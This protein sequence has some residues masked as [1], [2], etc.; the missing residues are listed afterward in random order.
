MNAQYIHDWK[1]RLLWPVIQGFLVYV[2]LLMVFD[3]VVELLG[4][5]VNTEMY[6]CMILSFLLNEIIRLWIWLFNRYLPSQI[7]GTRFVIQTLGSLVCVVLIIGGSLSAYFIYLIG[8]R[9]G[10]FD[11]ELMAFLSIFAVFTLLFNAIHLSIVLLNSQNTQKIKQEELL[12]QNLDFQVQTFKNN[13]NPTFFYESMEQF[14]ILLYRDHK[15]A[16]KFI[17]HLSERYRY[18]LENRQ[19][20]LKPL[21]QELPTLESLAFLFNHQYDHS[22]KIDNQ[23]GP[24]DTEHLVVTNTLATVVE[25]LTRKTII[26]KERPLRIRCYIDDTDDYLVFE[27]NLNERF[28]KSEEMEDRADMLVRAYEYFTSKPFVNVKAGEQTFIKIPLLR[29]QA[30]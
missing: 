12:R 6:L 7:D 5:F 28:V 21:D 8:Y 13:I 20:E 25:L 9:W 2:L 17:Y 30:A 18:V 3:N 10:G 23:I 26:S 19:E 4:N 1:F 14:L 22:I 27:A 16:D 15:L 24:V 29:V 11:T